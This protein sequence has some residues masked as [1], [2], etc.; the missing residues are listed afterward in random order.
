MGKI[1]HAKG[2]LPSPEPKQ[3]GDDVI[4]GTL[5]DWGYPGL[6][7]YMFGGNSRAKADRAAKE[8]GWEPQDKGLW[9]ELKKDIDLAL[10]S[11]HTGKLK[12]GKQ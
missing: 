6:G 5:S 8:L 2:V 1:L 7:W 3:V 4:E 12:L 11:G 10:A 9:E